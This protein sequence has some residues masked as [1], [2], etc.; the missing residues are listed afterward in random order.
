[1]ASTYTLGGIE[2]IA[3]GE[4]SNTWGSTTNTNWEMIEEMVA[5][6]ATISLSSATYTLT[7]TDGASSNGRHAV[8][9]FTG[10]PGAT[11]L[12]T[13][14]PSDLQKVYFV[15]NSANQ[16]V[17]LTQGSGANV[18]VS[19]G[20]TKIVYCDGAGGSASVYAISGSE[21]DTLNATTADVTTL[22]IGGTA[23]TSTADEL[24]IL[25]GVTATAAEINKL[26]GF[27]GS[28]ADLNYAKDLNA[29]GVTAAEFDKLDGL[30][31]TT[32]ELNKLTGVTSSTAELN[33]VDGYAGGATELNYAKALYDTGVTSVEY[34]YL[35]GV[36]SNIQT[37]LGTKLQSGGTLSSATITT[38]TSTTANIS[39]VDLGNWTVYESGG[40]LYFK[41]GTTVRMRLDASG[42]LVVE[43]NITAYGSL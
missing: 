16:T 42:N 30:T 11:C 22:Q 39:T 20:D 18:D 5:G 6:V 41:T 31:A 35:D 17:T 43:G 24:N 21:F 33:S 29:T 19:P 23:V 12:V 40:S 26:D 34:N 10:S 3:D 28:A 36:T 9:V 32:A 27:T 8:I 4:Q 13:V 15:K 2:L 14:S 1:M 7:T 25:D 37:Q 38:L